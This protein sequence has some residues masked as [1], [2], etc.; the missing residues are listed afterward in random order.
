VS[1]RGRLFAEDL[2]ALLCAALG[3]AGADAG[4]R[5]VDRSPL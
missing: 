3:R 5:G 1:G 4:G 2:E